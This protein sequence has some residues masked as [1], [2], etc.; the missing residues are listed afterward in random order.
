MMDCSAAII[1]IMH[2]IHI[3][4]EHWLQSNPHFLFF[5]Q[6]N[7]LSNHLLSSC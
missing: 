3:I 7:I 5:F 2:I 4:M 6:W 1:I